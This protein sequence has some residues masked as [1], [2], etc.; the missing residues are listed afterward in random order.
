MA[1]YLYFCPLCDFSFEIKKPMANSG[2]DETCP[3]C[4]VRAMR[5]YTPVFHTFGWK[6]S[7]ASHEKGHQDELVRNV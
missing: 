1:L 5:R 2:E 7:D 4:G 3:K 6:L